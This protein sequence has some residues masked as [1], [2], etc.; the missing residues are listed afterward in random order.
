MT[1]DPDGSLQSGLSA[2]AAAIEDASWSICIRRPDG[3][4]WAEVN[5]DDALPTASVGKILL[6]AET[7][8]QIEG[9]ARLRTLP[10]SRDLSEPVGE[11]GL[12]QQMTAE[13]LSVI[14]VVGLVSTLS[15]NLATNVLLAQIGLPAVQSLT[16]SLGLEQTA[17]LDRVR[18]Q[19]RP[20]DPPHLSVG[21]AR[22][23][24]RIVAAIDRDELIS[25]TVSG[26]LRTWLAGNADLSMVLS[27]F[28][29]DPLAH[30]TPDRGLTAWNKTGSDP[31]TRVDIGSVHFQD[32]G[33]SYAAIARWPVERDD[34]HDAVLDQLR[35]IGGV[36]RRHLETPARTQRP[37][38]SERR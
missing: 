21:N 14:D 25:P 30:R 4:R 26:L 1:T 32:R 35:A 16:R 34:L 27:A 11:A 18:R 9:D 8:R 7:A 28:G 5:A 23:L 12:W 6:L 24:S 19:R 22:E 37:D 29:L 20:E 2:A 31:G 17:L 10:L 13:S 15:D 36:L 33:L 38:P 3:S